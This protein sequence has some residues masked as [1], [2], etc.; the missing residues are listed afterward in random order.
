MKTQQQLTHDKYQKVLEKLWRKLNTSVKINMQKFIS[1]EKV[2]TNLWTVLVNQGVIKKT[3]IGY[4]W[5]S[6]YPDYTI[7][8]EV[9]QGIRNYKST[10]KVKN[11]CRVTSEK[12]KS[13]YKEALNDLYF[14]LQYTGEISIDKF[15]S[16]KQI[17]KTLSGVL[18]NLEVVKYESGKWIW[19]G[20]KPDSQMVDDIFE[21]RK[22]FNETKKSKNPFT[23]KEQQI[24]DLLTEAHNKYIE[25]QEMHP[26]DILEW[27]N[28]IHQC[29]NVLRGRV[30]T[31]D[32]PDVFYSK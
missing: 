10:K 4:E 26:D 19:I 31:R 20:D 12:T 30:V 25:L 9:I 13:K 3:N 2:S 15:C 24:V 21:F 17:G 32:Y 28:G 14:L 8:S 23:V 27:K 11:K 16:E 6:G 18:Q 5:Q 29:Q 22:S 1:S 7:T